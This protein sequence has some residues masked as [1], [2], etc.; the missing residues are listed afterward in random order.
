M[1]NLICSWLAF[2][3]ESRSITIR[4]IWGLSDVN[5]EEDIETAIA[6]HFGVPE[7]S[8][9]KI[10]KGPNIW[11]QFCSEHYQKRKTAPVNYE[12]LELKGN[13]HFQSL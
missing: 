8:V 4:T 9:L 7:K 6:Y 10:K 11:N 3:E 5:L 2:T 12:Q 1:K 13:S